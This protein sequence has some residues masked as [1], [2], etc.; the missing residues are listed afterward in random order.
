LDAFFDGFKEA[1]YLRL[2]IQ[3]GKLI[4]SFEKP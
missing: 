2:E 1:S 3:N 4:S